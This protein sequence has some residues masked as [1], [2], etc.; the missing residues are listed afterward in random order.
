MLHIS[1]DTERPSLVM[2][3][4]RRTTFAVPCQSGMTT[5]LVVASDYGTGHR[6]NELCALCDHEQ[7]LRDHRPD[8]Q[9]NLR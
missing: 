9:V 2:F 6:L 4:E 5:P 7:S 3:D 8:I 1:I